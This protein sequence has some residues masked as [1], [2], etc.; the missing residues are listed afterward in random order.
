MKRFLGIDYGKKRVGIALSDEN[1]RLAFPYKILKHDEELPDAIQN[2]CG[3]QDVGEIILGES[4]DFSG[5][6]N[7][8]MKEIEKFKK[9]ISKFGIPIHFQKEFMTSVEARGREGKEANNAR[10]VKN[11]KSKKIDDSAAALILQ[12]YLEKI[13]LKK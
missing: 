11:K 12:R 2:I 8:I 1:G 10:K 5:E 4:V 13:N 3:E 9:E 7:D 6:N